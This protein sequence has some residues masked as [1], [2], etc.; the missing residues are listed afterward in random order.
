MSELAAWGSEMLHVALPSP[1]VA[2][3]AEL[4]WSSRV[5]SCCRSCW[6][7]LPRIDSARCSVCGLPW[8]GHER[9]EAFTCIACQTRSA[10]VEWMEGWGEYRSPL[11]EVIHA[12]KFGRHDFLAAPLARLLHEVFRDRG[13]FDFNVVVPVPMHQSKLRRRGYNQA[14]LLARHFAG[15]ASIPMRPA[16]LKKSEERQ[17]QSSL[18]K[19]ERAANVKGAFAASRRCRGLSVL[20]VDDI[21]TTGETLRAC[22]AALEAAGAKR[23]AAITVA[24]A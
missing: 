23:V 8:N 14:R 5:G 15:L 17:N 3:G 13:D 11:S 18:D 20:L 12:F 19:R 4:G 1:C 10:P 7:Q 16:L 2:C 6:D 24:R 9:S 22:G 21:C